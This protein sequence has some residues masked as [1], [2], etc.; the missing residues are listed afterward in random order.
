MLFFSSGGISAAF[1]PDFDPKFAPDFTPI[2]AAA[3]F[4]CAAAFFAAAA[5]N[6]C[7][8]NCSNSFPIS[9]CCVDISYQH[10]RNNTR[11]N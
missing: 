11:M 9:L 4:L 5:T 7:A 10:L 2:A 8:F 6:P 1:A 3:V